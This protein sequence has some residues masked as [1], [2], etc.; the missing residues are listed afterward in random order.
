MLFLLNFRCFYYYKLNNCTR[1]PL[2]LGIL[3]VLL[4]INTKNYFFITY[5]QLIID[6]LSAIYLITCNF[7]IYKFLKNNKNIMKNLWVMGG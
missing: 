2:F 1:T 3:R 4:H 6:I 7:V 5:Q